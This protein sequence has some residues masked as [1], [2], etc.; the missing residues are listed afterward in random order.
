MVKADIARDSANSFLA[1]SKESRRAYDKLWGS[2]HRAPIFCR[3]SKRVVNGK[4]KPFY[5]TSRLIGSHAYNI[6]ASGAAAQIAAVLEKECGLLRVKVEKENSRAPFLPT[7]AKGSKLLLEQFLCAVAQQATLKAHAV[8]QC[9]RKKRLTAAHMQFGWD[10]VNRSVFESSKLLPS[11]V[12]VAPEAKPSKKGAK[13]AAE[14]P[15]EK[16]KSDDYE[17]EE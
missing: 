5:R 6:A 7:I 17:E 4:E 1:N 14:K 11:T 15:G 10:A 3:K 12:L 8:R 13:K 2:A 16:S 9:D